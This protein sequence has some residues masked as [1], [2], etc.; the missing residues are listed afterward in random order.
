MSTNSGSQPIPRRRRSRVGTAVASSASYEAGWGGREA[1]KARKKALRGGPGGGIERLVRG[2][3]GLQ[4]GRQ[5]KEEG[6]QGGALLADEPVELRAVGQVREGAAQLPPGE[7]VEA[8]F[9]A[10]LEPLAEDGQRHHLAAGEGRGMPQARLGGELGLAEV[11]HGAVELSQEG[12]C[13]QHRVGSFRLQPTHR[14][15]ALPP[16]S[17]IRPKLSHQALK[18]S[19]RQDRAE[20]GPPLPRH[21]RLS[22]IGTARGGGQS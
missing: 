14:A 4:G 8:T 6:D 3:L 7:A 22:D 10:E 12:V 21:P 18:N 20:V 19:P 5:V 2:W 16:P 11:V 13:V 9:A 15:Q 17:F 1:A